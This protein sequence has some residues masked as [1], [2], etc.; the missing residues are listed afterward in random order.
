MIGFVVFDIELKNQVQALRGFGVK[1]L[2]QLFKD[3]FYR[4]KFTL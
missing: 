4:H 3:L 2:F 1:T